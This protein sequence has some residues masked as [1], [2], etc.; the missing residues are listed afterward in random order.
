MNDVLETTSASDEPVSP[1]DVDTPSVNEVGGT[2]EEKLRLE[3][4]KR[5]ERRR[6]RMMSPEE[7][8]A[9]ITGRPVSAPSAADVVDPVPSQI[10]S[11]PVSPS[12]RDSSN[13][14][15]DDPPLENLTRDTLPAETPGMEGDLLSSLLGGQASSTPVVDPVQFSH[16][17]WPLLALA[18]RL[19]LETDFSWIL[20]DNMIAPFFLT[21]I[22]LM[23]TGY[24]SLAN[25]QTTS[26]LTAALMLCGVDQRKVVLL[27]QILHCGRILFQ[28]FSAYLFSF[29]LC[30][31]VL[32]YIVDQI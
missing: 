32:V 28:C 7:R 31:A 9:M 30:H 23:T 20:A 19:L 6:R 18:V 17:V 16:C 13:Q 26:L 5:L 1:D 2:E 21:V 29:L 8:L 3:A 12:L 24:L 4:A 11:V 15:G 22:V 10:D 25:L 27:T 14:A